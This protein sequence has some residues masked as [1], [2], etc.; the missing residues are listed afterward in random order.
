MGGGHIAACMGSGLRVDWMA[1]GFDLVG[2]RNSFHCLTSRDV[3]T[4]VQQQP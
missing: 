1:T 4:A 3:S 2:Y